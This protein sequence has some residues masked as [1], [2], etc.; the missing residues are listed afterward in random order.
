MFGDCDI[1]FLSENG[2]QL[3]HAPNEAKIM[4]CDV[5]GCEKKESRKPPLEA[6]NVS[7]TR[8][9]SCTL[10]AAL[11]QTFQPSANFNF[12]FP[13]ATIRTLITHTMSIESPAPISTG[14]MSLEKHKSKE[15]KKHK[16][17]HGEKKRKRDHNEDGHRSKSKKHRSEKNQD[18]SCPPKPD[19][20]PF[21]MQPAS[22]Y[23]PLAPISQKHPLEGLCAEHLS[24][25]L[26]T[27][28]PPL[29]GVILSYSNVRLSEISYGTGDPENLLLHNI[30]EYAVSWCWVTADFLLF[31][32]ILGVELE[33]YVNLQSQGHVGVVCW[34]LFNASIEAKR[35][36]KDWRWVDVEE[37]E[38]EGDEAGNWGYA[39]DGVGCWVDE[40]NN[41]IEGLVKFN[42][43][44][45]ESSH[46]RERGFLSIE[47]TMLSKE[48]ETELLKKEAKVQG[49]EKGDERRLGGA[50]K[51]GATDLSVPVEADLMDADPFGKKHRHKY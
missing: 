30:D 9:P 36:P 51:L 17:S 44:E 13:D 32:P 26:L 27:Y 48:E 16:L 11:A 29:S 47:G 23:L 25:L 35:L 28:Y 19:D 37:L 20:S 22:L 10:A 43:L 5:Q 38:K 33:G 41:K 46:D 49:I 8:G 31:K 6:P 34:N 2:V 39:E 50:K 14:K 12:L 24:P 3:S 42:V 45:I 7:T 4:C 40:N 21:H 18:G 1:I 15:G